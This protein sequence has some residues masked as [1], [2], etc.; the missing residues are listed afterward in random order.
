MSARSFIARACIVRVPMHIHIRPAIDRNELA[1][2][3]ETHSYSLVIERARSA[4]PGPFM[5]GARV[6]LASSPA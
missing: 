5:L 4:G 3:L 6:T 1:N 2:S